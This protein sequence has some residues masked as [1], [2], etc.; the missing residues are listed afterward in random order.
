MSPDRAFSVASLSG[1]RAYQATFIST[2][3]ARDCE[4][5]DNAAGTGRPGAG[6]AVETGFSFLWSY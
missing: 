5:L 4:I 1:G 2:A 6:D 3:G